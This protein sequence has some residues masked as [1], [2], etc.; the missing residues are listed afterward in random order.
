MSTTRGNSR[1]ISL[2]LRRIAQAFEPEIRQAE[3]LCLQE[4]LRLAHF[5]ST[6]LYTTARLEELGHPYATR[7]PNPPQDPAIV[8]YQT[9]Q[10]Y[11]SWRIIEPRKSGNALRSRLVNEEPYARYLLQ[12]TRRMIARPILQ[13]I[14]EQLVPFRAREYRKAVRQILSRS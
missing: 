12:G 11:R 9:G 10:F 8:N 4:A 3:S 6:G 7:R 14:R 2:T 1:R 5:Y 13:K